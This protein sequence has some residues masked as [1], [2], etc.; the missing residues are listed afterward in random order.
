MKQHITKSLS[1]KITNNAFD[2][3][4][5]QLA[6]FVAG[7]L[8]LTLSLWKLTRLDLNAAQL[9]FG[10]LLSP[11]VPLLLIIMG[12]LLPVAAADKKLET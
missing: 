11:C 2:V 7:V 12:L 3:R 4:A 10:V 9:F 5:V 8:V 1:Y 6:C